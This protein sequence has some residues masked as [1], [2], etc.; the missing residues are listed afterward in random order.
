MSLGATAAALNPG[1]WPESQRAFFVAVRI[2]YPHL[3][4]DGLSIRL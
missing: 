3:S 2:D 4:I 1:A